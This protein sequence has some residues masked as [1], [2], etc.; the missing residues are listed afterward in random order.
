MARVNQ[1]QMVIVRFTASRSPYTA[2]DTAGFTPSVAKRLVDGGVAVYVDPK[3]TGTRQEQT[4]VVLDRNAPSDMQRKVVAD[5]E[6]THKLEL[7]DSPNEEGDT[8]DDETGDVA[9]SDEGDEGTK[10]TSRRRK[11]VKVDD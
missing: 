10:R 11:R 1:A 9:A 5:A 2:N 8:G 7:T 4:A 3:K 6:E